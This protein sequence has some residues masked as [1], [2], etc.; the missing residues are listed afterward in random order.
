[1]GESE[2]D[3]STPG[4]HRL[5]KELLESPAAVQ[6]LGLALALI[7]EQSQQSSTGIQDRHGGRQSTHGNSLPRA[8][9][10]TAPGTAAAYGATDV[11][12]GQNLPNA[13]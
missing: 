5:V 10:H 12:V 1:M 4:T 7:M 6:A 9:T 8:C 13:G 2:D 11:T 3:R